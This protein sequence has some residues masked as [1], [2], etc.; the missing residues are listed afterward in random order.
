[1]VRVEDDSG[2]FDGGRADAELGV[3]CVTTPDTVTKIEGA[4]KPVVRARGKG[5]MRMV[6][7]PGLP[8]C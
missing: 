2:A 8:T 3:W 5:T 6:S 4:A 7:P 1:M